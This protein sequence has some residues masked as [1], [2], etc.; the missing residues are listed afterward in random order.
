MCVCGWVCVWEGGGG[1]GCG[2][3]GGGGGAMQLY[4][5]DEMCVHRIN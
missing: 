5:C 2:G 3:G 1:G 4:N